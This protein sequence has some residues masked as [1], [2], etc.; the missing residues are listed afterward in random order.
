[1]ERRSR[2][3]WRTICAA[4]LR[5][6]MSVREFAEHVGVNARTLSWWRSELRDELHTPSF[7]E[8]G[9][10]GEVSLDVAAGG[11][12]RVMVGDVVV[13]M[14]TLPPARWLAELAASC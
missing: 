12:I 13:T 10:T 1:M 5:S 7:V 2:E 9:T 6:G 11:D 14:P 3:Q 8:V 4:S